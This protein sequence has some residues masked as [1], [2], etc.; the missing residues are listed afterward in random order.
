LL[1]AACF[2]SLAPIASLGQNYGISVRGMD[3]I[4]CLVCFVHRADYWRCGRILDRLEISNLSVTEL[5][6]YVNEGIK[7]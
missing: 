6:H 4:I 1:D 5:T 7:L 3:S 2:Y